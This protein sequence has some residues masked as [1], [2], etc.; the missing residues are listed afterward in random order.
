ME[1]L[2]IGQIGLGG[3]GQEHLETILQCKSVEL[4]AI[5]DIN[6]ELLE[7]V[8]KRT[9]ALGF[10]D[11]REMLERASLDAVIIALP[12]WLHKEAVED[13]ARK[14][15][16]IL[17]E[18][19]LARNLEEAQ[20]IAR[21]VKETG[22]LLMIATQR[23]FARTFSRAK[24]LL[25]G[26]FIG[27]IF[28]LRGHFIFNWPRESFSWRGSLEKAGG[29]VVLDA[30]YHTIDLLYWYKGMPQK[31]YCA[32]SAKRGR[33]E[34][35]YETEDTAVICLKYGDGSIAY[36]ALSWVTGPSEERIIAHGTEGTLMVDWNEILVFEKS[37]S[38]LFRET[39]ISR[40]RRETLLN[41]LEHFVECVKRGRKPLSN[42]EENLN[43]MRI[44]E[45]AYKSFR[46]G[47]EIAIL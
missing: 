17:K 21:I 23:R 36:A 38:V 37:G 15:I 9:G 22:V 16:N 20:E 42:V 5:C 41:Q 4:V 32:C 7:R 27:D 19:P 39:R 11:Y 2:R 10:T 18:K 1:T 30:G 33:P 34:W 25:D 8:A 12:H 31:V 45:G 44:I 47:K 43:V 35:S 6:K 24:K 26:G 40:I 3:M 28:L 29:G 14:G 46:E 13:A